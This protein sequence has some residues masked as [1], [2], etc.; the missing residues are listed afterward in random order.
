MSFL[1][2][3]KKVGSS[4]GG[5]FSRLSPQ[6]DSNYVPRT[7]PVATP[8]SVPKT[9]KLSDVQS[10]ITIVSKNPNPTTPTATPAPS[11]PST[12]PTPPGTLKLS[13]LKGNVTLVKKAP[14]AASPAPQSTASKVGGALKTVGKAITSS[15]NEAGND[16]A[17]AIIPILPSTK[18]VQ[19]TNENVAGN[20]DK[21]Q[22]A[23]KAAQ[24]SGDTAKAKQL[25][26]FLKGYG[27]QPAFNVTDIDPTLKKS[28]EQVIGDFAGVA[29]DI[30]TAGSFG[31]E[32]ET[33]KL[34]TKSGSLAGQAAEKLGIDTTEK[35]VANAGEQ[36]AK[37]TAAA[38]VKDVAKKSAE[39]AALG[40]GYDVSNKMKQNESAKDVVK[41][42]VGTVVGG[43]IPAVTSL[44]GGIVKG[45]AG[46][47]SGTGSDVIQKAID[48][49]A[50]VTD[51]MR[52]YANNPEAKGQILDTAES[53][54]SDFT[55]NKQAEYSDAIS[56]L[57]SAQP[58][59][60]SLVT[61][62][63]QKQVD[64]FGGKINADGDL[65]FGDS[66]LTASDKKN[67]QSAW[68]E[69]R[70]WQDVTPQ[71]MDKLRQN[72][73]NHMTDF[74]VAGNPRANVVLGGVKSALTQFMSD[75]ISGYSDVLNNYGT[76][77]DT[78]QQFLKEFQ[79]G[80]QA[81][82]TT[83]INNL[84]KLFQKNPQIME[85]LENIMGKDGAQQFQNE[86]AGAVLGNWFNPSKVAN[87]AELLGEGALAATHNLPAAA[88]TAAMSSPRIVGES[89]AAAGKLA[90]T[91]IPKFFG[92]TAIKGLANLDY[93]NSGK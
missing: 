23:L 40:Y 79:L 5:V 65:T 3:I 18:A 22:Q 89:A 71:G 9:L 85:S 52:Q 57:Q 21:I 50:A 77:S 76:K 26:T 83:K 67:L 24:A 35:V 32:G 25:A 45:L 44:T 51:A 64:K 34:L 87:T 59:P 31:G 33:G 60:K 53:A 78:A 28:N 17:G 37:K 84:L 92:R 74:K 48:N 6:P 70:A 88:V 93:A 75:N 7:Q 15:E 73:G 46:I 38:V 47:L 14:V 8:S 90:Q 39:G 58:I 11:A 30:A 61:D 29:A 66:T 68:D 80:G 42:G 13:D 20:I 81:K 4:I 49:P 43:A 41:P 16:I 82:D 56:K 19:E 12:S 86:I 72:I 10:P 36:A 69:I 55:K 91:G 62:T 63:F 2:G 54:I 1:D 27:V